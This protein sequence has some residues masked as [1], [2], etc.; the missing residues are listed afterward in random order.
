LT[1]DTNAVKFTPPDG[2]VTVSAG[3]AKGAAVFLKVVDTG[4]GIASAD[5]PKVLEPF[6]RVGDINTRNHG[7]TGLG[8]PLAKFFVEL[9]GGTLKLESELDV[10]TT[11]TVCF[12]PERTVRWS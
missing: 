8:L 7:G 1:T 11:V 12:P 2:S 6:G 10:G 9:H 3:L 4:V 5:I